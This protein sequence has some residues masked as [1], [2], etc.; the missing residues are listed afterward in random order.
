MKTSYVSETQWK[1]S[2]NNQVYNL[3][4]N[5]RF[6]DVSIK[7]N[8]SHLP[9]EVQEKIA[10]VIADTMNSHFLRAT[11]DQRRFVPGDV[12]ES[13]NELF[14]VIEN[15][16]NSGMVREFPFGEIVFKLSWNLQGKIAVL[17]NHKR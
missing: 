12:I 8:A 11:N 15:N 10:T 16:G 1:V 6:I 14:E 17:A 9:N 13:G 4:K 7:V 2:Y 3:T 5:D